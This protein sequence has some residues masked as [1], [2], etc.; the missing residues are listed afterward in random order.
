MPACDVC[1]YVCIYVY[2]RVRVFLCACL[3]ARV[4]C[5]RT[6]DWVRACV[7]FCIYICMCICVWKSLLSAQSTPMIMFSDT[8]IS[9][10]LS[11]NDS[12]N[13]VRVCGVLECALVCIRA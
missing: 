6:C 9:I 10:K 5:M 4:V 8:V 13:A 1:V 11:D 2:T 7:Y 12:K 3:F